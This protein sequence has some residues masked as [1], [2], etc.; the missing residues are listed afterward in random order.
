MQEVLKNTCSQPVLDIICHINDLQQICTC[1]VDSDTLMWCWVTLHS[2]SSWMCNAG[3][4]FS[5]LE[6]S[7]CDI[8]RLFF[9]SWSWS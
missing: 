6:S 5:R 2:V 1:S 4:E 8:F 7:F 3:L 9:N